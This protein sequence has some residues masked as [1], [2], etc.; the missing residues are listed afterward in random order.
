MT[1]PN[2]SAMAVSP[3]TTTSI[4]ETVQSDAFLLS[5]IDMCAYHADI[6]EH[7]TLA[8]LYRALRQQAVS[9]RIAPLVGSTTLIG[10]SLQNVLA[11]IAS[12]DRI[13]ALMDNAQSRAIAA[14]ETTVA[15]TY[16][17]MITADLFYRNILDQARKALTMSYPYPSLA[18]PT[19]TPVVPSAGISEM[20]S[21]VLSDLHGMIGEKAYLA[22]LH[23]RYAQKAYD[24]G[25]PWLARLF[26]TLASI[27]LLVQI[28]TLGNL[29][30][31]I[32]N[33]EIMNMFAVCDRLAV[34]VEQCT[35]NSALALENG[36]SAVSSIFT[37]CEQNASAHLDILGS[38]SLS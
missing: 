10:R 7:H 24:D 20:P 11:A 12:E 23:Q 14:N 16:E 19:P 4:L 3:T 25:L 5:Y 38:M 1:T 21:I 31:L 26:N 29:Y 35:L 36:D 37:M 27:R 18:T 30:G 17:S 33:D 22:M 13:R 2:L 9:S 28:P 32:N 34:L 8:T 15:Q 6:V